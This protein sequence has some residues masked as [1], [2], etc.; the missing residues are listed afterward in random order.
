MAMSRQ[1]TPWR[2]PDV[3]CEDGEITQKYT[4]GINRG[5]VTFRTYEHIL[6]HSF[7]RSV[8]QSACEDWKK[9]TVHTI[10]FQHYSVELATAILKFVRPYWKRLSI[11]RIC[12]YGKTTA[13]EWPLF[14]RQLPPTLG[15]LSIML[16]F[17]IMSNIIDGNSL[18][19]FSMDARLLRF[20]RVC[21]VVLDYVGFPSTVDTMTPISPSTGQQILINTLTVLRQLKALNVKRITI[22]NSFLVGS[23][24]GDMCSQFNVDIKSCVVDGHLTSDNTKTKQFNRRV[25]N[26]LHDCYYTINK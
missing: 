6:A 16:D 15:T 5:V 23:A 13:E 7:T 11:I 10:H 21:H 17:Y 1:H 20:P 24:I 4:V 25:L 19:V 26:R 8:L 22:F 12:D 14:Y 2:T 18:P 3:L 9:H